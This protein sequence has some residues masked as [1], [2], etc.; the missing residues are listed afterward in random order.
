MATPAT[1]VREYCAL[2]AKSKLL[3]ADE[4]E[5]LRQKWQAEA[6]GTDGQVEA[7][8]KYLVAKRALTLWQSAMVQRGRADGF[9]LEDYRIL[10]QI[11]KGQMGGVYKAVHSLGQTVALKILPASRAKDPRV[12]SRFQR[13]ARLLTLLDHPN[14]VRAFQVG[15][16][17]GRYFIAM[18][19]LEGQTLDEVLNARKKL[20]VAE[21]IRLVCQALDGLQHL[22]EK[23]TVHR[24]L[25]PSNLMIVPAAVQESAET[26]LNSTVKI[27]DIGLGREMF[28][29]SDTGEQ[30]ETQLT[31]EGAVVGT[32]DYMS[33]EQAKDARSSDIRADIYSLGCV[34][35]HCLTGRPP[36]TDT[37]IMTQM[38]KHATEKPAPLTNFTPEAT[39]ALQAVL[40]RMMAKLP[41]ERY[42]TPREAA[43]A[44]RKFGLPGPTAAS[45]DMVPAYRKWLE[46][47]S[48][49]TRGVPGVQPDTTTVKTGTGPHRPVN[50]AAKPGT[51]AQPALQQKPKPAPTAAP[52][53]PFPPIPSPNPVTPVSAP[54]GSPQ[55]PLTLDEEVEVELV[56]MPAPSSMPLP[57]P[58]IEPVRDDRGLLELNRRDLIMLVGGGMGVIGALGTG[59]G[60]ARLVRALKKE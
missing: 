33:P 29:E 14:V 40:D 2:L 1:S 55:V 8:G 48:I 23:R 59:Y 39:A 45:A 12:L 41:E 20:P 49:D 52:P 6:S 31:I 54:W 17:G 38:L 36:F 16:S 15:Q 28:A 53:L 47:E 34:L 46:T 21:S 11:G 32:P 50:A 13:E 57:Q 44:L 58:A 51:A 26:T 22:H 25:K 18:E 7:F 35:Y 10:D 4:V 37:N 9:F 56:T 3:P 43:E 19:Y 27:L 60:L 24:D 5:S 42:L 30:T